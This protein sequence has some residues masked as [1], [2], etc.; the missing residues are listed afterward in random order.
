MATHNE[1]R[2]IEG[3]PSPFCGIAADDLVVRVDGDRVEV[4]ENGCPVTRPAF[5]QPLGDRRPRVAGKEVTLDEAAAEAARLLAGARLP[6]YGGLATDVNGMRAALSLADRTGG[7]VDS[8]DSEA[9]LRNIQTVQNSGWMTTTLSEVKNRA[10]LLVVVG[11]DLEQYFPRFFSRH[12]WTD[13]AMFIDD[14]EQREVVFLGRAPTGEAAVTPGGRPPLLLQ[15]K[16]EDL[17][18]VVSVLRALV[19]GRRVQARRV[20]GIPLEDLTDLAGRLKQA[21]YG[22]VTWVAGALQFP[23]AELTVEM[24]CETIKELNATTRCAGLPLGGRNGGQTATQVCTWQT[25]YP[26]RV[27]FASGTPQYDPHLYCTGR[28]LAS[29][30]A[31]CLVWVSAYDTAAVP[32]PC[33]VPTIV[34]GRSG[35]TF[36]REPDVYIPVGVP[37]IDHAGHTYRTD[38]VVAIRLRKLRDSGLPSTAEALSAIE[39]ALQ[40]SSC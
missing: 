21:R 31:D 12:L 4:I 15:C 28:L 25:G 33:E 16:D 24:L 35:M 32:P 17:P 5:E 20:G 18:E 34:L 38:N 30:E 1:P 26:T 10:D 7:V 22:V 37:G 14:P 2:V 39:H 36:D 23:G 11:C 6:L 19:N 9:A 3:V 27:S 8:L 13:D 29:G 40:E